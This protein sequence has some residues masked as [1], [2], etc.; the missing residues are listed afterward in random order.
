MMKSSK[1]FFRE[2]PDMPFLDSQM[3]KLYFLFMAQVVL[4]KAPTL[5]H[6]KL[7]WEII[8][9]KPQ[10]FPHSSRI[11]MLVEA[12]LLEV[13]LLV[14][15]VRVWSRQWKQKKVNNLRRIYLKCPRGV[16]KSPR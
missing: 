12:V 13:T 8:T 3:R 1:S 16:I 14:C 5:K 4:G 15:P 11:R 7:L 6:L 10:V 2:F 9:A